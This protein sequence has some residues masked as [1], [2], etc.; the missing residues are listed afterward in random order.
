MFLFLGYYG[1]G[2][3]NVI[4]GP[5]PNQIFNPVTNSNDPYEWYDKQHTINMFES[6][7]NRHE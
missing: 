6:N 1:Y 7:P 5:S 3:F 4:I 2:C